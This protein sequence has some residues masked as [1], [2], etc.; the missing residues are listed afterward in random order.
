MGAE[1]PGRQDVEM[2][3]KEQQAATACEIRT[4]QNAISDELDLNRRRDL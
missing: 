2:L 3:A 1:D 4:S